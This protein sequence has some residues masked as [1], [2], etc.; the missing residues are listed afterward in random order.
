MEFCIQFHVLALGGCDAIMGTQWLSTLGEIQW[1]FKLLTMGF[2]YESHKLLL[3]GLT[4]SLG[5]SIVYC[6][7]IFKASV[8]KGLLLQIAN[9]E[10]VVTKVRLPV[11]VE[12]LLQ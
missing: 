1:K 3:Q 5:S 7:Q 8:K 11:E 12:L 10:A 4:P 2:C 9:V 6:K